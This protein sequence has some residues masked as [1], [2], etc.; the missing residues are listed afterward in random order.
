M[1]GSTLVK[2]A[3][4]PLAGALVAGVA[5]AEDPAPAPAVGARAEASAQVAVTATADAKISA[6]GFL[7]SLRLPTLA[8]ETR[9]RGV[10]DEDVKV[11]LASMKEANVPPED[12]IETFK[13]TVASIDEKGPVENF[14]AFV[15]SKVKEGL[16]GPQLAKAIRDEH[17]K[18]GIGKGKK[19]TKDEEHAGKHLGQDPEA[20]ALHMDGKGKPEDSAGKGPGSAEL[21]K[22]AEK[23]DDKGSMGADKS[24]RPA[25]GPEGRPGGTPG[26]KHEGHSE[27]RDQG[28]GK[29]K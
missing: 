19:L 7:L 2:W 23:A 5:V 4:L 11:A 12:A 8:H 14:G 22:R 9:T 27:A 25:A 6:T 10:P 18:R 28:K 17:E 13:A 3:A 1:T 21:G 16:R 26:V 24:A 15:Q 20:K 29:G